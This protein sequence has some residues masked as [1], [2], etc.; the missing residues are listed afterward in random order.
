MPVGPNVLVG[1]STADDASVYRID[2]EHAIVQS[3][4]F[5]PPV[6]DDPY[7]YGAIAAANALSDIYAMGAIPAFALSIVGFPDRLLPEEVLG[8]ILQGAADKALEAGVEILGGHSVEDQE[9][10]FG[11]VVTGFVHPDKIL[12]NSTAK[13]GN[14]LVLTKPLGTGIITTAI[15]KNLADEETSGMVM[16][17]MSDLNMKAAGIM[18]DYQVNACTD[19]TGFGFLGHLK[20]MVVGSGV[21]AIINAGRMPF[22]PAAMKLAAAGCIPGGTHNNLV[23]AGPMTE[24]DPGIAE[25]TR[26]VM[27]DAQTSGGLLISVPETIGVE[28]VEQL[29]GAG[30]LETCI[31]GKVIQ[32]PPVIRVIQ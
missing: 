26:M 1:P 4:D 27:A 15:K 19:I 23:F 21:T 18:R 30:V 17:V 7:M 31:V 16:G 5:I 22:M 8:L 2:S 28:M 29:R 20:E 6:V 25:I 11:L 24:W 10:K 13:P 12:R 3:V 9:P 32:G 14:V